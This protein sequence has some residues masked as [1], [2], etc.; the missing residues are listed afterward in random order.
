MDQ[1]KKGIE[2]IKE[3]ALTVLLAVLLTTFIVSHN[4]I[5]TGSMIA[6]INEHDHILVN[7]LPYYYRDPV[8]GEIVVFRQGDE[9]WVKR[10]IGEPGDVVDI[11]QGNV[12][13]N[14]ERLDERA[15]L[16]SEGTSQVTG[17]AAVTFPYKLGEKDYFLMGDN[18]QNS[19]DSR[20]IGPISRDK[21]YGKGWL[22]IYPFTQI[23]RLR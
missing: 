6:T 1:I 18:R 12:Y 7:L 17:G 16:A 11:R 15:Y 9:I 8:R 10:A 3:L 23:G 21:I 22:K 13:I 14:N 5:P 4:E 19:W 20:Y 2:F